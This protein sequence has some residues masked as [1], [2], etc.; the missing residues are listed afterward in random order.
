MD[1]SKLVIPVKT[2][3]QTKPLPDLDPRMRE[4]DQQSV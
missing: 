4:D 2:G 3:I 1:E